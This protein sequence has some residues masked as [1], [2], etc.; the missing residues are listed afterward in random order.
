MSRDRRPSDDSGLTMESCECPEYRCAASHHRQQQ[1]NTH[2]AQPP[3]PQIRRC[4]SKSAVPV[5]L[6][7]HPVKH[8]S[9]LK[10]ALD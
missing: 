8:L 2:P 9:P 1:Q 6:T 4:R 10:G 3:D 5:S 7:G